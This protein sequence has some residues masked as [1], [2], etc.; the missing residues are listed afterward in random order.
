MATILALLLGLGVAAPAAAAGPFSS[1]SGSPLQ[2]RLTAWPQ[3]SLPAPLQRPGQGDLIYPAWFAGEWQVEGR[4]GLRHRVRFLPQPDGSA[5]GDRAFNAEAVGRAL[6]G[7]Q[8]LRVAN[9]PANPNRQIAWLRDDQRLESTVIGRRQ[10]Q[11]APDH[12]LADELSLQVLHRPGA[13]RLSQVETLSDYQ[14][15][16]DG[17][18]AVEQW[19]ARY[20][21]PGSSLSPSAA[22]SSHISLRLIPP[23]PAAAGPATDPAS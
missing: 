6:L 7:E 2:R 19:Q 18:I 15:L 8:L 11:P 4:D 14:L 20:A 10:E 22:A 23:P 1:P 21:A 17:S 12:L 3:W 9:D 16:A 13:P 5:R